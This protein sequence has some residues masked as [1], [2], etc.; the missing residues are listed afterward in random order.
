MWY[1]K[2]NASY[3]LIHLFIFQLIKNKQAVNQRIN[4]PSKAVPVI[5]REKFK[6]QWQEVMCFSYNHHIVRYEEDLNKLLCMQ[7]LKYG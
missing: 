3:S 2:E 4:F 5:Y 7:K 1:F 6:E